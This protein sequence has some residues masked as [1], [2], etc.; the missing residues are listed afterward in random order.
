M[1]HALLRTEGMPNEREPRIRSGVRA[2]GARTIL[3]ADDDPS[4]RSLLAAFLRHDGYEV[5]E[6]GSGSEILNHVEGSLR[7]P[8][9]YPHVNI[10]VTDIHMPGLSGLDAMASLAT[11]QCLPRTIVMTG[12]G[13]WEERDRALALG[14][15]LVLS[16]P[17]AIDEL[18]AA[19]S[20][21]FSKVA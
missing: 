17:F 12:A 6:V 14:A 8:A 1:A 4:L 9:V 20:Q 15:V 5:I 7:H 19:V 21:Q 11:A 10:L 2:S 3:L 18:R 13:N 16:K